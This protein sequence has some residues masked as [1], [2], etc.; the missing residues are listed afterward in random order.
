MSEGK[1]GPAGPASPRLVKVTVKTL[2]RK[3]PFEVSEGT[4][5]REFKALIAERFK[6]PAEQLSLIFAGEIL[7]DQDTLAQHR[8]GDGA[9]VHL[10]IKAQRKPPPP[11]TPVPGPFLPALFLS[12]DSDPNDMLDLLEWSQ[13]PEELMA[14]CQDLVTRT[15]EELLL[16]IL[17]LEDLEV[18]STNPLVLGFLLG[19]TG[20]NILGLDAAEVSELVEEAAAQ[21]QE[22][23][24]QELLSEVMQH[25]FIQNL[26]GDADRVRQMILSV[27]QVRQLAEQNPEIGHILNDADFLREMIDV[28]TSPAVMDEIIRNHD[29][30]LSNLESIPGGYSALQQLYNDIEA[31]ML[32]ALQGNGNGNGNNSGALES[33]PSP[34]GGGPLPRTENREPLPNPWALQSNSSGDHGFNGDGAD[35]L[36]SPGCVHIALSSRVGVNLTKSENIQNMV[37]QLTDN[38]AF[39]Q[40]MV[41]ALSQPDG[42]TQAFLADGKGSPPP[43]QGWAQLLPP[44]LAQTE[45]GALLS[46]PRAIQALLQLQMSLLALRREAPDF[47]LALVDPDADPESMED[48]DCGEE[49]PSSDVASLLSAAES[50]EV[51]SEGSKEGRG[52]GRKRGRQEEEEDDE[53]DNDNEEDAMEQQSPLAPLYQAQLE[54]LRA[55]GFLDKEQNL[56]ALLDSGGDLAAAVEKLTNSRGP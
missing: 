2:K 21:E 41:N 43:P 47:I 56:R 16:Q 11:I 18:L 28:A 1:K 49:S 53:D 13:R 7:R 44:K 37:Q 31:P 51:E 40:S 25:P 9:K 55:M 20:M 46:N 54:Q 22:A 36:W 52:R 48:S 45:C 5:V 15:M 50:L 6:T 29:R 33:K 26:F 42:P 24:R 12:Q 23:S 27:P 34:E 19:V 8:I 4:L 10:F 32:N 39:M 3:E 35:T 17:G 38:P 14:S 30:A